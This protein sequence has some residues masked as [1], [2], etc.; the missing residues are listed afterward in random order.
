MIVSPTSVVMNVTDA[1]LNKMRP[2]ADAT[3]S[4]SWPK[5]SPYQTASVSVYADGYD[6]TSLATGLV[7]NDSAVADFVVTSDERPH[8]DQS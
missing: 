4:D 6:V 7:V 5:S 1:T 3:C 2:L 8:V